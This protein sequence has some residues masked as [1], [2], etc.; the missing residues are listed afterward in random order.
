MYNQIN[1]TYEI[2]IKSHTYAPDYENSVEAGSQ[3]EAI[4]MF[5]DMLQGEFDRDFIAEHIQEQE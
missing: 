5:Y 2:Y 3:A 1:M 4:E